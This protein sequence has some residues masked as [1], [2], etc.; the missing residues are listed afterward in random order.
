[1]LLIIAFEGFDMGLIIAVMETD[2]DCIL[3]IMA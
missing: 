2:S 1:V 3:V